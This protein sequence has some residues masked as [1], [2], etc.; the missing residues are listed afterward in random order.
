MPENY[1]DILSAIEKV[2]RA[3]NISFSFYLC[4]HYRQKKSRSKRGR[5][6]RRKSK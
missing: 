4:I 3:S 2:R 1:M 6:K 5:T